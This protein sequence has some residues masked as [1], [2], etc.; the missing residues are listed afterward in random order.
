MR[1][2][3]FVQLDSEIIPVEVSRKLV[4]LHMGSKPPV[5]AQVSKFAA[6]MTQLARGAP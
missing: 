4:T 5:G 2:P 6:A 3:L 1:A